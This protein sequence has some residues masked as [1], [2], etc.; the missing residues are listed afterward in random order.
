MRCLCLFLFALPAPA[1]DADVSGERALAVLKTLAS[2]DFGGRKSGLES[3]RRAEEWMA[4]QLAAIGLRPW[5]GSTYYQEFKASV[6]EESKVPPVFEIVGGRKGVFLDDYVSLNYSGQGKVTA[7][8]VF[9]G[10]GIR[11]PKKSYDDYKDLD[12]KGKIVMAVRGKPEGS[13]FDEERYIGYKSSTAADRGAIGF[14]LVEG[15]KAVPGTIQEKYHRAH[16]PAAWLSRRA[17]DDLFK[18][19]GRPDLAAQVKALEPFPLGVQVRLEIH[20]RLLKDQPLRNV[21]GIWPG[22]TDEYV[23][24]GA[25]LDHLGTDAVGNVYNGADDNASGSAMLHEVARAVVAGGREFRRT[26]VFCWFAGE[27]Q[28]L[29][30]S[31][32][33]VKEPPVPLRKIAVMINIDMVGQG[34]PVLAVGGGGAYPRDAAFLRDF[35]LEGFKIRRFRAGQNSDH[36]PFQ[37]KG[38]PAFSVHTQGPHPNYH[39]PADDVENIRP[40]LLELAGRFVKRVGEL[41]ADSEAAHC[42]PH[43][44]AEY[45]WHAAPQLRVTWFD[46]LAALEEELTRI[47]AKEAEENVYTPG[48]RLGPLLRDLRPTVVLGWRGDPRFNA[49]ASRLGAVLFITAEPALAQRRP[50]VVSGDVAG[51]AFPGGLYVEAEHAPRLNLKNRKAPWVVLTR[52]A[53]AEEILALRRLYGDTHVAVESGP[54]AVPGLLSAGLKAPE[55][56]RLFGGNFVRMLEQLGRKK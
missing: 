41:A 3:G 46:D 54:E 42:R 17:A 35:E 25:H 5:N 16:L 20:A 36:Y 23:V 29:L 19:A 53:D 51:Y 56:R 44:L 52:S 40:E 4:G 38:V 13:L 22:T 15:D 43:R 33:F 7:E 32:A 18:Q 11:A 24:V 48:A 55:I 30:G 45:I 39:R 2:D 28:G 27:E 21:I 14:L 31:G 12:V 50:V 9:V 8:V 37:A 47:E 1:G 26:L 49:V 10:Y 6:T 34:K